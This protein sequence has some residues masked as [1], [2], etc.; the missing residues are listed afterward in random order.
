MICYKENMNKIIIIERLNRLNRYKTYFPIASNKNFTGS[1]CPRLVNGM[2]KHSLKDLFRIACKR[3]CGAISITIAFA[4][5]NFA[6]S[7][8]STEFC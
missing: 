1:A 8:N 3:P 6:V 4:G 7:S 5:I 2:C